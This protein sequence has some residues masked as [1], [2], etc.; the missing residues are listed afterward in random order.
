MDVRLRYGCYRSRGR[1]RGKK[2]TAV[3]AAIASE[4]AAQLNE[5][6]YLRLGAMAPVPI[7]P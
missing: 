7:C 6:V 2:E 4:A 1:R 3:A 5:T